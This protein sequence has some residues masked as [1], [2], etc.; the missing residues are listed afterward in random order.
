MKYPRRLTFTLLI[1]LGLL[2]SLLLADTIWKP[3][4]TEIVPTKQTP[5][6][7]Q[8][9]QGL[10]EEQRGRDRYRQGDFQEAI[11]IWESVAQTYGNEGYLIAQARVL[12]NLS[13]A[14]QHLGKWQL[15]TEAIARSIA[16]LENAGPSGLSVFAQAMNTQGQLYLA[17][18]NPEAAFSAWETAEE[19]YHRD[20]QEIGVFK[21]RINQATA[22]QQ[23][24]LYRRASLLLADINNNLQQQETSPEKAIV[25]IRLGNLLSTLSRFNEAQ[26][27]LQEGLT[28]ATNL[29]LN[30]EQVT[31]L[32]G[33]GNVAK[34]RKNYTTALDYYQQALNISPSPQQQA[35]IE[36]AKLSLF[37]ENQQWQAFSQLLPRTK[38]NLNQL[39]SNQTTIYYRLNLGKHWSA[40][41]QAQNPQSSWQDILELYTQ[42]TQEAI[43][44]GDQRAQAFGLGYIASVYEQTQ[45]WQIAQNITQNALILSQQI[46]APDISYLW[47]WQLGR[48]QQAQGKPEKAIYSYL[49]AVNLIGSLSQDIASVGRE[50]QFSFQNSIEPVYRE[51]VSLLL[52]TTPPGNSI[53]QNNLSQA[54]N[55]IESL[56]VA[57]LDKFFRAD[58]VDIVTR[59]I[60]EIDPSAAVIYPI[61]L[62]DNLHVIVSKPNQPLVHHQINVSQ[63]EV[64]ATIKQLSEALVI[65][66]RR[67]FYEPGQKLYNWVIRPIAEEINPEQIKTLVFV[68]DGSFRNIPMATLYDGEKYLIETYSI[69]ITPGLKLLSDKS[70]KQLDLKVL[71]GGLTEER[72]GFSPLIYVADE[73]A[74]IQSETAS[75]VLLNQDFTNQL[76][77]Q[78]LEL[79]NY[80]IVHFATHDQFSSQLDETFI[81]AWDGS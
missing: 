61:I 36:L 69:A 54:I 35:V 67:D 25:L 79:T 66:S 60:D 71:A 45:Q 30:S 22:L 58:C 3:G 21:A 46:K 77:R 73:I 80:P 20:R 42:A 81:L 57:E 4:L 48:I 15:A 50:F 9:S 56:K 70:I 27:I 75:K 65:R 12:S 64:E 34:N 37:A 31:A 5:I 39:P 41:H 19:L 49:E 55:V 11:A 74:T 1:F 44:L 32:I 33:L 24:G 28:I 43:D 7:S 63:T 68:P 72:Y 26:S 76:I 29:N 59:K 2:I 17:T 16:L 38:Y 51:L 47:L 40:F 6:I 18:G 52:E 13:L 62:K 14:Y 78:K 10:Q 23:L 8:A 53:S